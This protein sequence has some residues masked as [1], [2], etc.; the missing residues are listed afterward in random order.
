V[1][2]K[3]A[4]PSRVTQRAKNRLKIKME[5][6]LATDP[7]DRVAAY[8]TEVLNAEMSLTLGRFE[9]NSEKCALVADISH[10]FVGWD[11]QTP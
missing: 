7:D 6:R 8:A 9:L 5:K 11:Q 1:Q 4:R 10:R 3:K 2:Q